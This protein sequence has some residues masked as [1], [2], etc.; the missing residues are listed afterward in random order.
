MPPEY[1][2]NDVSH[3]NEH[4]SFLSSTFSATD[5]EPKRHRL[6]SFFRTRQR[7]GAPTPLE[8]D[9]ES[10][11]STA[12]I[13]DAIHEDTLRRR[14]QDEQP[15]P[16]SPENLSKKRIIFLSQR[17]T[18][19]LIYGAA[20]IYMSYLYY[21]HI[22]EDLFRY[23]SASGEAFRSV[24][25][26][27]SL[28]SIANIAMGLTGRKLFGGRSDLQL[29]SFF[30][31]GVAQVFAKA[32]TSL[33]LAA[34]LSFPVCILA[35]SAKIVPVMLGQLALG[36]SSYG[37]RDY[38]FAILIV[39][40][41]AL[42]SAGSK[43]QNGNASTAAGVVCIIVSLLMD[44]LTAGLQKRLLG[45]HHK[46]APPTTYD[47][48]LFTNLA[49]AAVAVSIS[50]GM[51]TDG[52]VGLAFLRENS[53]VSRMVLTACVCSAVGQSFI[54]F[55]VAT[56]DPL[57]CSTITT[58]RKILSVLWS[59]VT[60]GHELSGQG[61]VGLV[62]AMSGLILEAQGRAS[63]VVPKDLDGESNETVTTS[64]K[65]LSIT[66]IKTA[67]PATPTITSV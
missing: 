9:I 18:W 65:E 59:I 32:L 33:A 51:T 22:Q 41:T 28:E 7:K 12:T 43:Q 27:Q 54:F 55:V 64:R 58:T 49:M 61:S 35:K 50:F 11:D 16:S 44:G 38:A 30:A 3:K 45:Q 17:R 56:F 29:Q 47:F 13:E 2:M 10:N 36:G 42:L 37:A 14:I 48:L 4:E 63:K 8:N 40:G 52:L 57:V 46:S 15:L 20:G 67:T 19:L 23:Q 25:L 5:D 1:S 39:C 60:K 34:G 62:L 26:L 6:V 31:T 24:W 53:A 21:G 66:D